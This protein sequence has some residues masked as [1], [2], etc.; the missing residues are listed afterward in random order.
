VTSW[1]TASPFG[2]ASVGDAI[3]ALLILLALFGAGCGAPPADLFVVKRTGN[4]PGAKLEMLVSDGSVRCNG[5]PRHEISSQQ[6]LR[7]RGIAAALE[8][9]RQSDIP[10]GR[11]QIF[12]FEVQSEFGTI[13][14]ADTTTRPE[15]LPQIVL[16]VRELARN[17]CGL[18]R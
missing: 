15:V 8:E 4:V 10:P 11:A 6:L 7:G 3:P 2:F 5:G 14:F 1:R 18:Q 9:I 17:V 12:A 16:L 13:R